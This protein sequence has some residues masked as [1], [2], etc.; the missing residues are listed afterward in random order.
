MSSLDDGVETIEGIGGDDNDV[1]DDAD[2]DDDDD[3]GMVVGTAGGDTMSL[4]TNTSLPF[5][6]LRTKMGILV[7]DV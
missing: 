1:S 6:R 5:T 7:T 4:R 2:D 3:E